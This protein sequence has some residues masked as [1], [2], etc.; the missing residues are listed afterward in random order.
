MFGIVQFTAQNFAN[1]I[2]NNEVII[3]NCFHTGY[4]KKIFTFIDHDTCNCLYKVPIRP[5]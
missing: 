3:S 4:I 2:L 1:D 5:N